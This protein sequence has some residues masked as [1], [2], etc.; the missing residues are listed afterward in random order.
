MPFYET[1]NGVFFITIGTLVCGGTHLMIKYFYKSKCKVCKCCGLMVLERDTQ[2]E[3]KEDALELRYNT[4]N[5]TKI[6]IMFNPI[7]KY[8]Q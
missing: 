8:N 3:Q 7:Q 5:S 1:F 6:M 4:T 2:T